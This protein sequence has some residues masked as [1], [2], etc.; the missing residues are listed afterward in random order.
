MTEP[1]NEMA[2]D[3]GGGDLFPVDREQVTRTL[4]A[5]LVQGRLTEDEYDERVGR[6]SVSRYRAELAALTTDLPVGRM[7]ALARAPA[8]RHVWIGVSVSIAA[9]SVVAAVLLGHPDVGLAILA[10]LIAAVTVLVAPIVTVGVMIDVRRQKRYGGQLPPW[11]APGASG[12]P[13]QRPASAA[14]AEPLPPIDDGQQHTAEAARSDPAHPRS[15]GSWSA[16]QRR[17]RGHR[18]TIGYVGAGFGG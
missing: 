13:S 9:A 8:A 11:P 14:P 6:A 5:A 4:K 2:A 10:F 15:P 16:H 17:H 7:D 1:G 3:T 18:H 12:T